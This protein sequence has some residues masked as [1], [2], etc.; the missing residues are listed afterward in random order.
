MNINRMPPADQLGAAKR[1]RVD[2]DG[3]KGQISEANAATASAAKVEQQ[4]QQQQRKETQPGP[5][6]T[7]ARW[8]SSLP[9]PK[10][11]ELL[12]DVYVA[13]QQVG[14]LLRK[15]QQACTADVVCSSVETMTRRRCTVDMLRAVEAARPGTVTFSLRHGAGARGGGGCADSSAGY[16]SSSRGGVE[17]GAPVS[18][19]R[20]RADVT[21]PVAQAQTATGGSGRAAAP[22]GVA[23]V[24]TGWG[25]GATAGMTASDQFRTRLVEMVGTHHD[26]FVR[27]LPRRG[28][29]EDEGEVTVDREG[30][31]WHPRFDLEADVPDPPLAPILGLASV[32][33]NEDS[34]T[35]KLAAPA[36]PL[37]GNGSALGQHWRRVNMDSS[38]VRAAAIAATVVSDAEAAA[39]RDVLGDGASDL[40]IAAVAAVMKRRAMVDHETDPAVVAER[41]R[42]RMLDLLPAL[43]D[44]VRSIFSTSKR[45][46][47]P[48]PELLSQVLRATT[49]HAT[50]PSETQEALRLLAASA[51]E[52]CTLMS[53]AET[54]SGEELWRIKS[55]DVAVTRFVREKLM[56]MKQDKL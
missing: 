5:Q 49:R 41:R 3:A 51:P 26:A 44:A 16:R 37:S 9:L 22:A 42:R 53:A 29:G 36:A 48:F 1:R 35:E 14:P 7:A 17:R 4:Q 23:G 30:V 10:R 18:P 32:S 55:Q 25:T 45:R 43:F 15:R 13:L 34:A 39:A 50:S 31:G 52:W 28:D 54:V 21:V 47:C 12:V 33:A 6:A 56:A 8:K 38:D 46:V 27:S 40:P 19:R 2:D 24:G 11:Y 20:V